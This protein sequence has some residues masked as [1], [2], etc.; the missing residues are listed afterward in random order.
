MKSQLFFSKEHYFLTE[1]T[2][3]STRQKEIKSLPVSHLSI[4][5]FFPAWKSFHL[6]Q[7]KPYTASETWARGYCSVEHG[8]SCGKWRPKSI[9]QAELLTTYRIKN[10][11]I[12]QR[13]AGKEESW[14]ER[15]W[16][17][18]KEKVLVAWRWPL[19]FIRALH[20][21]KWPACP[22]CQLTE[23]ILPSQGVKR[24]HHSCCCPPQVKYF[25]LITVNVMEGF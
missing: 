3:Q 9:L 8:I 22:L 15:K 25:V 24:V 6:K 10:P 17:R 11:W 20:C 14:A 19:S 18:W 1:D 4:F 2:S 23:T 13:H 21:D 12:Y 5:S 7:K 16:W